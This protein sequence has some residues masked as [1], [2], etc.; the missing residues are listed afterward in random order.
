MYARRALTAGTL[1]VLAAFAAPLGAAAEQR[2]VYAVEGRD[3]FRV[4]G[5]GDVRT[6]TTYSGT[7]TLTVTPRRNGGKTFVA[8][9]EY[10]RG[11]ED[12]KHRA[13]ASFTSTVARDGSTKDGPANDP[14][15]LTV[16]NQPFA[17]QLDAATMRD[18]AHVRRSVPFAFPSPMTGAP[19][20]GTLRRLTD[21]IIAGQRVLGIAFEATGPLHGA[22]PDRPSTALTGT[23]TMKGNAYYAYTD[24]TLVALEANLVIDGSIEGDARKEPV[25]ILYARSIRPAAG[26]ETA[27]ANPVPK[28]T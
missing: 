18:L 23:I 5:N 19:L 21:G 13:R 6:R 4:G 2:Q 3:V 10:D 12:G 7:Q 22:L 25:S 26:A 9:V 28:R 20:R 27:R 11:A 16:L 14:D 24:A 8:T 15:Y 1:A 17:V